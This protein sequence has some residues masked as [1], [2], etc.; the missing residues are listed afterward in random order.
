MLN[1]NNRSSV[2]IDLKVRNSN[3]MK[4]L[5]GFSAIA[6]AACTKT[7]G[8]KEAPATPPQPPPPQNVAPTPDSIL[9]AGNPFRFKNGISESTFP[10]LNEGQLNI[11]R[12]VFGNIDQVRVDR[13][14]KGKKIDPHNLYPGAK[15]FVAALYSRCEIKPY[16][17]SQM[18]PEYG[19]RNMGAAGNPNYSNP[20]YNPYNDMNFQNGHIKYY[21]GN[22]GGNYSGN[23]AP[24]NNPGYSQLPPPQ[25]G[26]PTS[27]PAGQLSGAPTPG[28]NP[29]AQPGQ[30][31]PLQPDVTTN[32]GPLSKTIEASIDGYSCP[33]VYREMVK[34]QL[35]WGGP[36]GAPGAQ[37][38]AMGTI[39]QSGNS[40]MTLNDRRFV[41]S[42]GFQ[43]ASKN[44]TGYGK[45]ELSNG[46]AKTKM[47]YQ[48]DGTM[49]LIYRGQPLTVKLTWVTDELKYLGANQF[50]ARDLSSTLKLEM[51]MFVAYVE[52]YRHFQDG[53]LTEQKYFLNGV[54]ISDKELVSY[55]AT[56]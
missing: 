52:S 2:F 16:Y 26:S 5:F 48:Y 53:K 8:D 23:P 35:A 13:I 31:Q 50:S 21:S 55:I 47:H 15:R 33:V 20:N 14:L 39:Q 45:T 18:S 32:P 7:G 51:P 10:R 54:P 40:Q 28:Q 41:E 49:N 19:N 37:Q 24:G 34:D 6:V 42:S 1:K 43:N 22:Y 36:L 12:E 38:N 17:Y 27:P 56:F 3:F 9:S 25:G 44:W 30:P 46:N 11:L 4:V 29:P